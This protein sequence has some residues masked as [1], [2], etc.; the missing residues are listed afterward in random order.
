MS[1]QAGMLL[2]LN[3]PVTWNTWHELTRTVKEG[4][5]GWEKNPE[6]KTFPTV[7]DYYR[8]RRSWR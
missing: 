3:K 6:S 5:T 4:G 8:V 2:N 7:F 1:P